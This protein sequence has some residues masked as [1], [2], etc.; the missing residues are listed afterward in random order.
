MAT[1]LHWAVRL[2]RRD[3]LELLLK[4]GSDVNRRNKSGMTPLDLAKRSDFAAIATLLRQHGALDELPTSKPSASRGV[5]Q[6]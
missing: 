1:P 5:A 6:A 3:L 4:S 2:D